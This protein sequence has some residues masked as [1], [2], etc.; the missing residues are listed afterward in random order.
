[1]CKLRSICATCWMI[2]MLCVAVCL[3]CHHHECQTPIMSIVRMW[4]HQRKTVPVICRACPVMH[5]LMTLSPKLTRPCKPLSINYRLFFY[6]CFYYYLRLFLIFIT[7]FLFIHQNCMW[8]MYYWTIAHYGEWRRGGFWGGTSKAGALWQFNLIDRWL[9]RLY[10][11]ATSQPISSWGRGRGSEFGGEWRTVDFYSG[12]MN[13]RNPC[14]S[15]AGLW[16][17]KVMQ[18]SIWIKGTR[19]LQTGVCCCPLS[20]S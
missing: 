9:R 17:L 10:T 19:I 5:S 16:S 13:Y 8:N 18:R 12:Y 14:I 1:M 2:Y 3:L 7:L 6:F 20:C 4:Q 11:K 15:K